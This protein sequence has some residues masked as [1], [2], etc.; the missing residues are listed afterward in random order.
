MKIIVGLGNPGRK[1][2]GTRH[3]VG[4]EVVARLSHRLG[5][6]APKARFQA[7]CL[8]GKGVGQS[9]LLLC[10]TTLMN[11]SGQ[12]VG[13]AA[14]F[15]QVES[16]DVMVVCDDFHLP[17][18]RLRIRGKGSA[19]GQKGLADIIQH[20]GTEGFPRLRVGIGLPPLGWDAADFVLGR[21][22][23]DELA[24]ITPAYDRAVDAVLAWAEFG[25]EICMS[26]FNS[27]NS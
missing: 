4:F 10:P 19:G 13:A 18:A 1:Y 21:F 20:L 22:S 8:E 24:E 16:S 27:G 12:S 2:A 14:S 17:L 26:R 5:F 25:L 7:E 11:R 6:T 15:Y 23:P 9:L 3:N